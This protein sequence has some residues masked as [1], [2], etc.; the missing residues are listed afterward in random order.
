MKLYGKN[1]TG[2]WW[3][4]AMAIWLCLKM[5]HIPVIRW[6]I[7][8]MNTIVISTINHSDIGVINQLS[9]L[10]GPTLINGE[11]WGLFSDN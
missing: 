4:P 3:I 6:F 11:I 8:P 5:E 1:H 9:Y 7:N 10:G 2:A